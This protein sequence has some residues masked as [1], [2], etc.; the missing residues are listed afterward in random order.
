MGPALAQ[1]PDTLAPRGYFPL[2]V[3][4]EWEYRVDLYRPATI[5]RP[6]NESRSEYIRLR[7]IGDTFGPSADRFA[8]LEERFTEGSVLLSRDT[9]A[10]RYDD[11]SSSVV[12]LREGTG[13]Q[14]YERPFS[15]FSAGLDA[16]IGGSAS[17]EPI[18]LPTFL[19]SVDSARVKSFF[20]FVWDYTSV[21]GIGFV[22]GRGGCEPCGSFNDEEFWALTYAYVDGTTY[23]ARAVSR[24]ESPGFAPRAALR[25]YPNPA[26]G[27][28]TVEGMGERV[29][30][31]DVLGRRVQSHVV[32]PHE[33]VQIGVSEHPPGVYVVRRGQ[34]SAVVTVH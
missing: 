8:L 5:Y 18:Y 17:R 11:E 2:A 28:M 7:V 32:L 6:E 9:V 21:H 24:E 10:V 3:E 15:F 20:D 25:V 27:W 16:L 22:G 29:E 13:G 33:P 30:V 4:N 34:E 12:A 1:E 23:G 26:R 31:Y 19:D 14:S